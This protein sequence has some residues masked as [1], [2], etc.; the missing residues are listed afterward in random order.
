MYGVYVALWLDGVR[1]MICVVCA[2]Y[3]CGVWFGQA[4]VQLESMS[5]FS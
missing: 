5:G 1:Q 4:I 2:G 3:Q